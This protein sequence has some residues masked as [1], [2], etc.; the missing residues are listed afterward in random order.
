MDSAHHGWPSD[1]EHEQDTPSDLGYEQDAP[2]DLG[3]NQDAP[4]DLGHKQDAPSEQ[5]VHPPHSHG[6]LEISPDD[7]KPFLFGA[8]TDNTG[9]E[10]SENGG[11]LYRKHKRHAADAPDRIEIPVHITGAFDSAVGDRRMAYN[12]FLVR[13]K[14]VK[15]FSLAAVLAT[16]DLTEADVVYGA[17]KAYAYT[18]Y[19]T[20]RETVFYQFYDMEGFYRVFR[21][22][23]K[24]RAVN[25][26]VGPQHKEW[27]GWSSVGLSKR[28]QWK[29]RKSR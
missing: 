9:S 19:G 16:L 29:S 8:D 17:V 14:S 26:T 28:G 24:P 3:H 2:S 12:K 22:I 25:L 18:G 4:S 15:H 13:M 1:L 20:R 10:S 11:Q 27:F 21:M 6:A 5:S 23:R 7:P